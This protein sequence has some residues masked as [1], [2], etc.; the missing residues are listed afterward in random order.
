MNK[1]TYGADRLKQ[2][3]MDMQSTN[4]ST[5]ATIA[6]ESCSSEFSTAAKWMHVAQVPLGPSWSCSWFACVN[7]NAADRKNVTMKYTQIIRV[8]FFI[9]ERLALELH[10][11]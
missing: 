4:A 6:V 9:I 3:E 2:I 11:L 7:T 8:I 5:L 1:T 10:D